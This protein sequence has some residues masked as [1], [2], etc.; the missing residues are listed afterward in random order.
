VIETKEKEVT[1]TIKIEELEQLGDVNPLL[2]P[3]DS[4]NVLM[5]KKLMLNEKQKNTAENRI[6]EIDLF[7]DE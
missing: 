6:A 5:K 7:L 1:T 2:A 3:I 4:E